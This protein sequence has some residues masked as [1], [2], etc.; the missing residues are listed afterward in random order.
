MIG[1]IEERE[2]SGHLTAYVTVTWSQRQALNNGFSILA[3]YIFWNNTKQWSIAMTAPVTSKKSETIAMTAPVTST[4]MWAVY[5]VGFTMPAK[6][7][8]ATLPKPNTQAITIVQEK[9]RYI[10]VWKF[11]GYA[12][13]KS[14]DRQLELFKKAL[15]TNKLSHAPDFTLAQYNDPR[16]PWFMRINERWVEKK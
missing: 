4:N 13:E 1:G 9:T 12:K 3:D 8:L 5:T 10:Y 16:T 15:A 2:M 6:Y 14:A 7:T 11:S